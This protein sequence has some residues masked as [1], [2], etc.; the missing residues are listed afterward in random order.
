[1]HDLA[2]A[3]SRDY[4]RSACFESKAPT[5]LAFLLLNLP[6]LAGYAGGGG[7]AAPG[8]APELLPVMAVGTSGG[9]IF[10]MNPETMTVYAKLRCVGLPCVLCLALVRAAA[11]CC[12]ASTRPPRHATPAAARCAAARHTAAPTLPQRRA[13]QGGDGHAGNVE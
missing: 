12:A 2:S 3:D 4:S 8:A 9:A 6:G 13:R 11:V 5:A 1:M 7:A 10:L